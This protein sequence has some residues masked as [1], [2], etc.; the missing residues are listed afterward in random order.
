[1]KE[2]ARSSLHRLSDA[3]KRHLQ[4][5]VNLAKVANKVAAGEEQGQ[6]GSVP[7]LE[8]VEI[9]NV[10]SSAI[11]ALLHEAEWKLLCF[12][13][14]IYWSTPFT[15]QPSKPA[16]VGSLLSRNCQFRIQ[17]A[18]SLDGDEVSGAGHSIQGSL[19]S[20]PGQPVLNSA[21]GEQPPARK[22]QGDAWRLPGAP[23]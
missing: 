6:T 21:A 1:M 14:R 3:E 22:S 12:V 17:V 19:S 8:G 9:L 4:D 11:Q 2:S 15:L 23:E 13:E 5:L 10:G 16:S 20:Q 18:E 7:D